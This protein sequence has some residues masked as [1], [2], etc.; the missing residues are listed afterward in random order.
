[1]NNLNQKENPLLFWI[2]KVG[3][4]CALSVL[5]LLLCIPIITF[6]PASIAL[7]DSVAHCIHGPE[8]GSVRRFFKTLKNELPRG[9]LLSLIWL[10]I[11][12]GLIYG[13]TILL[14]LAQTTPAM[15]T[16]AQIYL[17]TMLIPVGILSWLIPVESRFHHSFF[18]LFRVSAFYAISHLPTT[19]ILLFVLG[20]GIAVI[21]FSQLYILVLLLPA[22]IVTVQ[23]WFVERIFRKYIPQEEETND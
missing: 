7:F 21:L 17:F 16:Y 22:I 19:A 11:G 10:M 1:M 15:A 8:D 13:Y 23:C 5:W 14:Q 3:D 6:I 18:G 12:F 20:L 4:F 9:I 2:S